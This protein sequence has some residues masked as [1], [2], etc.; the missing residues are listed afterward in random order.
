MDPQADIK[1]FLRNEFDLSDNEINLYLG[2]LEKGTATVLEMSKHLSMNRTTV[3]VNVE[4]LLQK[5][6]VTQT[7]EGRGR[8]RLIVPEPPERFKT[9]ID[10]KKIKVLKAEEKIDAIVSSIYNVF[11]GVKDNVKVDVTYYEG[12]D[13]VWNVY[14]DIMKADTMYSFSDIDGYYA[15]YPDTSDLWEKAIQDNPNRKV[16]SISL[17]SSITENFTKHKFTSEGR[18]NIKFFT[19]NASSGG[20]E[21]SDILVFD[22]KLAVIDLEPQNITGVVISSRSIV[23]SVKALHQI[24]WNYM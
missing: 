23:R 6:L 22:D 3:H 17:V 14:E 4:Y 1:F 10:Q 12:K 7:T 20:V 16:F 8:K 11:P 18:Y 19:K 13:E 5:G 15:I 2:L 24:L 9:I 21:H